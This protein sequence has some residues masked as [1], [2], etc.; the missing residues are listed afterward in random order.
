MNKSAD[1]K[2]KTGNGYTAVKIL[3]L[4]AILAG[5]RFCSSAWAA[6]VSVM[7]VFAESETAPAGWMETSGTKYYFSPKTGEMLTG[8]QK[9]DGQYYFFTVSG[10]KEGS[11]KTNC[12]AGTKKKGYYYVDKNGVRIDSDEMNAA[13]RYVHSH[14]KEGWTAGHKLKA[15]YQALRGSYTYRHFD[16]VPQGK[17]L[18]E[19]ACSLFDNGRGNCYRYASAMACIAKALGYHAR[20]ATGKVTSVHGGWAEHGWAQV[21]YKGKW[22]L[23]DVGMR[24]FMTDRNPNRTY[25]PSAIYSLTTENGKAVWE[26]NPAEV[27]QE[28]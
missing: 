15:C 4:A 12:I 21:L 6:E 7:P 23:C 26:N 16:G 28:R 24:Q 9:I 20:V 14:T 19:C 3:F 11:L 8:W 10:K 25:M 2:I 27:R 17:E 13:V 1:K 22:K 18:S 5:C